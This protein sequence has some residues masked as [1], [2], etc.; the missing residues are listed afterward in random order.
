MNKQTIVFLEKIQK[1]EI[2]RKYNETDFEVM[3]KFHKTRLNL[4][5]D[6][7]KLLTKFKNGDQFREDYIVVKELTEKYEQEFLNWKRT[8]TKE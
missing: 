4:C 8:I 6:Y 3:K 5:Y 2:K 7:L 1:L